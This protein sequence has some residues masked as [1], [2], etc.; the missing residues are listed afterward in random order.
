MYIGKNP[1]TTAFGC[2]AIEKNQLLS[3][4]KI[5][6]NKTS[7]SKSTFNL[8]DYNVCG[9]VKQMCVPYTP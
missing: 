4:I 6:K 2:E 7:R 5:K 3:E 1:E 8:G 9:G